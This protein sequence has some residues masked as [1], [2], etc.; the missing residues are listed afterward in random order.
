MCFI[1]GFF[2]L[3]TCPQ[4]WHKYVSEER[5]IL[6]ICSFKCF[7][8][9]N[10]ALQWEHSNRCS[11]FSR[12][13]MACIFFSWCL[14]LSIRVKVVPHVL[15]TYNTRWPWDMRLWRNIFDFVVNT[16]PHTSQWIDLH[17]SIVSSISMAAANNKRNCLQIS[18]RRTYKVEPLSKSLEEILLCRCLQDGGWSTNELRSSST[19]I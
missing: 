2:W 5:C 13:V 17:S 14:R 1:N 16:A 8:V 11:S 9:R 6:L 12:W 19:R 4:V 10:L 3:N 7:S 15:H 18:Q